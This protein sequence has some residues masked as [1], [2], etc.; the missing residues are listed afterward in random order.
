MYKIIGVDGREYGPVGT[1]QIRQW[2]AENRVHAQTL[3]QVVGSAEWKPLA[4]FP[5]LLQ[6]PLPAAPS[7][8]PA[9]LPRPTT[10]SSAIAG[11]ALGIL[12][13]TPFGWVCCLPLFSILGIIFSSRGL[14]QIKRNP[15][16]QTG[17]GIAT[18]GLVLSILGL[19]ASLAFATLL[20]ATRILGRHPLFWHW[21]QSW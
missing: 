17:K 15:L 10:N 21:Q 3:T 6:K 12:S 2:I 18:V 8:S 7:I 5:E 11:L 14:S 16:Q 13:M 20:G 9:S 19:V 4:L 1:E